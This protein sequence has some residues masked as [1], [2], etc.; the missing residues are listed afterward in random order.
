M[1]L[2]KIGNAITIT[3]EKEYKQAIADINVSLRTLKT[4]MGLVSEKYAENA[5]SVDALSAKGDILSRQIEEQRKKVDAARAAL[6]KSAE[7]Y[8]ESDT[9]T[10]K[11]QQSLNGAET[12]LLKMERALRDNNS[13]LEAAQ[14]ATDDYSGALAKM[15][16]ATQQTGE[17]SA[18]LGQG[19]EALTDKLGIKLPAGVKNAA[20]KLGTINPK[21]VAAAAGAAAL[22]AAV[23]KA[24]KAL[25]DM[26]KEAAS[27]ADDLAT[28]SLQTGISVTDLQKLEYAAEFVDV[29]VSTITGSITKLTNNMQAARDGSTAMEDNFR[30]LG[31]SITNTDGSLRDAR[32]VFYEAIDALGRVGNAT[33]RDA[34]AMDIF[35]K[36]AQELNPLILEGSAGLK[37]YMD[38]AEETGYV[39]N[40]KGVAALNNVQNAVDEFNFRLE[41]G[42]KSIAAEFAPAV[43]DFFDMSAELVGTLSKGLKNS[44][45]LE[46]AKDLLGLLTSIGKALIK[47]GE[48]VGKFLE[49]MRKL[50]AGLK[51]P[52][53]ILAAMADTIGLI[54]SVMSGDWDGVKTYLGLNAK[55]G[56]LSNLHKFWYGDAAE[57]SVWDAERG[58]WVGNYSSGSDDS[59]PAAPSYYYDWDRKIFVER[60]GGN[61]AGTDYWRGGMT[62]VGESGPERVWLPSGSRIQTAQE[63]R[64][65]GD[66]YNITIAA[67]DVKEFNDIVRIAKNARRAERMGVT[68]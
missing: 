40:E 46:I 26:T 31:V 66:V 20:D 13:Q 27:A 10:Q 2:G 36:S 57:T 5:D 47:G 28:L 44:G 52:L 11:W 55:N 37:A 58:T 41:G 6:E 42:K 67:K 9:R 30:K 35:G 15:D 68:G 3:G 7:V 18:T 38:R 14:Q 45:L 48:S 17:Q 65:G 51:G 24:E 56:K 21:F 49:S 61:A 59:T 64:G 33:E 32:E 63:S 16:E 53:E 54:S 43:E 50:P 29:S 4:E 62:W 23:V 19:L 60:T 34:L 1:A 22:A 12:D 8:G 25:I 39:L